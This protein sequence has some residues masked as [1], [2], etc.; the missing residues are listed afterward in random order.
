MDAMLPTQRPFSQPTPVV[1]LTLCSR[2]QLATYTE[3]KRM[4]QLEARR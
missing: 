1:M 2:D 4:G 3:K